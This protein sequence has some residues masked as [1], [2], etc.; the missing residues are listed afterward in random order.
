[1]WNKSII[2]TKIWNVL[3]KSLFNNTLLWQGVVQYFDAFADEVS[4]K[5][6]A[7]DEVVRN[8]RDEND[9]TEETQKDKDM[10]EESTTDKQEEAAAPSIEEK[11]E[12]GDEMSVDE[13]AENLAIPVEPEKRAANQRTETYYY[14][15]CE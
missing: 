10:S 11:R 3:K 8:T 15:Q 14:Y 7:R 12:E 2:K 6:E 1:M 9:A 5:N 4:D 13:A